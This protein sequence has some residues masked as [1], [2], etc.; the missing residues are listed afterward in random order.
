MKGRNTSFVLALV[1]VLF[2]AGCAW[3]GGGDKKGDEA[4][5][6]T[7]ATADLP[8]GTLAVWG[9]GTALLTQKEFDEIFD[10]QM[11]EQP[12]LQ[13]L[14]EAFMPVLKKNLFNGLIAQKVISKW[15][16]TSGVSKTPEY[17]DKLKKVIEGITM[18]LNG[19]YFLKQFDYNPT[20]ADIKK[21]YEDNKDRVA[22][23]SKG[24]VKASGVKFDSEAA[25]QVFLTAAKAKGADFEKLAKA[26]EK[27]AKN[28]QDFYYVNKDSRQLVKALRDKILA[29]RSFPTVIM[30]K[31]DDN[32]VWVVKATEKTEDKYRSLD[33]LKEQIE[34]MLRQ[35]KQNEAA[36]KKLEGLK[37]EY[38][39]KVDESI[40]APNKQPQA[41]G[42]MP[43]PKTPKAPV[44]KQEKKDKKSKTQKVPKRLAKA[45]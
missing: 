34:N 28:L 11:K 30:V 26:D 25:A 13:G 18:R 44:A 8:A 22:L 9:D 14:A 5:V 33:E 12:E 38:G 6:S 23:V 2:L 4:P 31:V 45:A 24:G 19:E 15:I 16:D 40:F 3:F 37:V 21:Y 35:T 39:V 7:V 42:I 32:T 20:A 17:A 27:L 36:M 1:P 29:L 41:P 10:M 43:A